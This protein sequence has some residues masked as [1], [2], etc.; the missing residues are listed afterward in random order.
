MDTAIDS[1]TT[2]VDRPANCPP[3]T[4]A[5]DVVPEVEEGE[6]TNAVINDAYPLSSQSTLNVLQSQP[7]IDSATLRVMA[8]GLANT[9]IGCTFQPLDAQD[10][11][12]QLCKELTD[13]RAAQSYEPDTECPEGYEENHGRLPN[14]FITASDGVKRQ[15]RY[16]K[17]SN[18]LWQVVR[19]FQLHCLVR[20][21][22]MAS[23]KKR[24]AD[25]ADVATREDGTKRRES[26]GT[27]KD[28]KGG[29]KVRVSLG[30]STD[31]WI[32]PI[33][34]HRN[35]VTRVIPASDFKA[36]AV[37][38]HVAV[39]RTPPA[40]RDDDSTS[41]APIDTDFIGAIALQPCSFTTGSYGWKGSKRLAI[42]VVDPT[43]GEKTKVQVMLTYVSSMIKLSPHT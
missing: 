35:Q 10:E 39:T 20:L 33:S 36:R 23:G 21:S 3:L 1:T 2:L 42:D 28:V 12:R 9:A 27:G 29:L 30:D 4:I 26:T 15:A 37:P 38:L 18:A 22:L 6:I 8:M 32:S 31:R 25:E 5:P 19:R 14:F 13:L 24:S 16:V 17:I 34:H 43:S 41:P 7:N 40:V 11:I